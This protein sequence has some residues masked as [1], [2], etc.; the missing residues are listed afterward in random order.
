M[1][2]LLL[3]SS[4]VDT[5]RPILICDDEPLL[6]NS[7]ARQLKRFGIPV[8]TDSKADVVPMA[9]RERPSLVLLDVIQQRDGLEMLRELRENEATRDIPVLVI[10]AVDSAT[11]RQQSID[12]GAIGF[13]VKPFLA[14]FPAAL[15]RLATMLSTPEGRAAVQ[16][17]HAFSILSDV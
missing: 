9:T 12:G 7:L 8:V 11:V 6:A 3:S 2:S 16:E 4:E 1:A 14:D 17:M 15:A 13:V 5:P 10:S